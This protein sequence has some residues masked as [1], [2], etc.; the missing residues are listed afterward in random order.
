MRKGF[1]T[2]S[3][4]CKLKVSI[5]CCNCD[6]IMF[7]GFLELLFDV[8]NQLEIIYLDPVV[9]FVKFMKIYNFGLELALP[10]QEIVP[11]PF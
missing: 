7:K 5:G 4:A 2:P 10:T 9:K 3:F 6:I 8:R 11:R 1:K